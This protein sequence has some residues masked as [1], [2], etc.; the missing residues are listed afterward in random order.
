MSRSDAPI[1][2]VPPGVRLIRELPTGA[3]PLHHHPGWT[4]AFPW[5][6]QGTTGR[7]TDGLDMGLF[8]EVPTGI[9]QARWRRLREVTGMRAAVHARQVHGAA[10]RW[11]DDVEPGLSI[12]E[13]TDGHATRSP[14][15]LLT[16]SVADCVPI[17]L[18]A[19]VTHAACVLHA[20]WRGIAAGVL[21]AGIALLSRRM[22]AVPAELHVHCGPAIC[23]E[24]YE[25]GAEVVAALQLE[26]ALAQKVRLDL[27]AIIAGRALRAGIPA[28]QITLSS[29]CT[30]CD[31]DAFWSHRGGC[32]ERQLAVAGV[33]V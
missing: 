28:G 27:R 26:P 11:H 24:C 33:R 4:A 10:V 21:E 25:V 5:L 29:H 19:G 13:G 14:G 8:G 23:G 1:P 22:G 15:V 7:G 17:F 30:R 32:G 16:V 2:A 12:G 9:A 18:I 31:A 3:F 6:V 20:G